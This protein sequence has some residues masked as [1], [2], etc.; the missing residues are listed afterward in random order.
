MIIQAYIP[1]YVTGFMIFLGTVFTVGQKRLDNEWLNRAA[2]VAIVLFTFSTVTHFKKR[3]KSVTPRR[4][5]ICCTERYCGEYWLSGLSCHYSS[6]SHL[7]TGSQVADI[8]MIVSL[9]Q[10]HNLQDNDRVMDVV[11][12][13]HKG[14]WQQTGLQNRERRTLLTQETST[15]YCLTAYIHS[16]SWCYVN[17][18]QRLL[19]KL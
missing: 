11:N 5:R 14:Y 10:V 1:T 4:A 6:L 2:E 17:K 15:V 3:R 7:F 18:N 16:L 12:V 13:V 8:N 19:I 9:Q